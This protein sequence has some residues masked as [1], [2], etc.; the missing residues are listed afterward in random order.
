[1]TDK[2]NEQTSSKMVEM[3]TAL[4]AITKK[5]ISNMG[6]LLEFLSKDACETAEGAN[7]PEFISMMSR[8]KTME[9]Q[10]LL[11]FILSTK[12]EPSYKDLDLSVK[13]SLS[14]LRDFSIFSLM[15]V[16]KVCPGSEVTGDDGI[17]LERIAHMFDLKLE[18]LIEA[19]T[20]VPP[21]NEASEAIKILAESLSKV[22]SLRK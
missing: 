15:D 13:H 5:S 8:L 18:D 3:A 1:M 14:T 19:V 6:A 22:E 21:A 17:M 4:T 16:N 20:Y 2:S 9:T 11:D 12:D 10:L 7:M